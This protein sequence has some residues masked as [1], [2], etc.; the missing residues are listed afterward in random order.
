MN[1]DVD[2]AEALNRVGGDRELLGEL[3]TLFL[4]ECPRQLAGIRAALEGNDC[5]KLHFAAHT[6]KGSVATFGARAAE[7]SA[8]RLEAL[9][10]SDQ[11]AGAEELLAELERALD[12]L[13]PVLARWAENGES[14]P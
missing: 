6:L 1:P 7:Q 3:A 14:K 5:R 12:Q 13:R 4:T 10:R 9:G 8:H 11:M 2:E